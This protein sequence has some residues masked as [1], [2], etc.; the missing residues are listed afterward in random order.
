MNDQIMNITQEGE[1]QYRAAMKALDKPWLSR[2]CVCNNLILNWTGS[3]YCCGSTCEVI[4]EGKEQVESMGFKTS[5]IGD[6][7]NDN[8]E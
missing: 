5:K 3:S 6:Q 2:C 8:I 1:E 7:Y 4:A